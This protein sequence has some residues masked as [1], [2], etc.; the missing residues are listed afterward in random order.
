[1][2]RSG[3]RDA[4]HTRLWRIAALPLYAGQIHVLSPMPMDEPA[5]SRAA[6]RRW[7]TV[8]HTASL[9][10]LTRQKVTIITQWHPRRMQMSSDQ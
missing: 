6:A 8:M 10:R 4:S 9:A 5:T 3:R 7:R 1:M 2:V